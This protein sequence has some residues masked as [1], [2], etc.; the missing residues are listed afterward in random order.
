MIGNERKVRTNT[1]MDMT[2]LAG[3]L[4]QCV[5]IGAMSS[6]T[7]SIDAS[8]RADV[9]QQ[10][11]ILQAVGNE[12]IGNERASLAMRELEKADGT[13]LL[14]VLEA[15][16][17]AN[18]LGLNWL[19]ATADSLVD[20]ELAA[21]RSLPL[22]E[23]G[24]FLLDIRHHPRARRYAF[25][26]LSRLE[27]KAAER[28]LP[29]MIND[30]SVELR[31]DAVQQLVDSA[32]AFESAKS[33]EAATLL[34]R[35]ALG[36]ARDVDQIET[37]T[38]GLRRLDQSVDLPRHFGFLMRWQVIGPFDNSGRL[39][40][41]QVF[42]PEMEVNLEASYP[43][44]ETTAKW[45][46]LVTTDEYGML[47]INKAFGPLKEAT[48]YAYT[49][50]KSAEARP[51]ELRLGCKNAWKIWLNGEFLFGRDEYHRGMRIDQYRIQGWLKPGKN[52]ILVKVCQNE[53]VKDWTVEWQFQ[54][55]VCDASGTAILSE[56]RLPA[57]VAAATRR[58]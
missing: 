26:L 55:R 48:A 40:F 11:A 32:A 44:K 22:G 10:I 46:E 30:P 19:R 35:Q 14:K 24:E 43:G 7:A 49:E 21:R 20:R 52:T 57:P 9:D 27:P 33:A 50:F 37:V 8:E 56:D 45:Q 12:G 53:E 2:K 6:Y 42:T 51:V 3:V 23:L 58:R 36:A 38:A 28:M 29:G 5:L 1:E 15:M 13:A 4:A 39:G 54:L 25:E 17:E 41:E 16:D 31:R 18:G 47:D 34:Y